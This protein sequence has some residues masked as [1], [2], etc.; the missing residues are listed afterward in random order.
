MQSGA[1]ECWLRLIEAI[2]TVPHGYWAF[3]RQRRL[4]PRSIHRFCGQ[5]RGSALYRGATPRLKMPLV[6]GRLENEVWHW[7]ASSDATPIAQHLTP[8]WPEGCLAEAQSLRCPAAGM[9]GTLSV[10]G[11]GE[12]YSAAM[13]RI[14]WL[15]GRSRVYAIT[16]AQLTLRRR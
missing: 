6:P 9:V 7:G 4:F 5:E 16:A 10:D 13:V 1:E 2:R 8:R 14:T 11:V 3:G 15:D 12:R